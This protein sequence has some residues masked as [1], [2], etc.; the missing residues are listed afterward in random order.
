MAELL[1]DSGLAHHPTNPKLPYRELIT[2]HLFLSTIFYYY[3]CLIISIRL[4]RGK[5]K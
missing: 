3:P 5:K 4:Q 1:S 2:P